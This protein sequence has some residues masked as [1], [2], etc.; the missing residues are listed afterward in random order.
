MKTI[1]S[2]LLERFSRPTASWAFLAKIVSVKDG[3]AYG[4][5]T[6]DDDI[7]FNDGYHDIVYDSRNELR[8]QNLQE[9]DDYDA[10][11]TNLLGWFNKELEALILAGRFDRAELTIYRVAYQHLDLGAE[12][13]GFGT[14]GT[15]DFAINS[16][17]KRKVEF[18]SLKGQLE[19]VINEMYSLT[20]RAQFGDARCKMPF[21][22]EN[23]VVDAVSTSPYL[24][25]SI[26]GP[27]RPAGY[28]EFGVVE[29][30]TGDNAGATL[31]VETYS[32]PE[33]DIHLS[34]LAPF[35][36]KQ[37]DE[38]RIRRD[39]GKTYSDCMGYGNIINMRAEHL[40]PV[41]DAAVQVPGAYIKSVSSQ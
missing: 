40:T 6:L 18:V 28:F 23:A 41:E 13:I 7:Q 15:V 17:F 10:G 19:Q 9:T 31:E 27:N 36:I 30:L 35:P 8:P 1:P 3:S 39:C 32:G 22:W 21:E 33:G 26:S 25:F 38:L 37:G 34:F 14:V 11:S 12:V 4:Y 24:D 2:Q 16:K 29:F 20:C 5:T